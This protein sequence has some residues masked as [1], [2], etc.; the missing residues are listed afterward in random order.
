M[1][2]REFVEHG[3][4]D[5]G[6]QDDAQPPVHHPA[7]DLQQQP[8]D[9][10][11]DEPEP[12]VIHGEVE[13]G[14]DFLQG[15]FV[16][17]A[18][19]EAQRVVG[20]AAGGGAEGGGGEL[21]Q[22]LPAAVAADGVAVGVGGGGHQGG[23]K[24]LLV[25][26]HPAAFHAVVAE[27]AVVYVAEIP[28]YVR[29]IR[30]GG[31]EAEK[32]A[33][34]A[35]GLGG[36]VEAVSAQLAEGVGLPGFG[37]GV[38]HDEADIH[39]ITALMEGVALGD[40]HAGGGGMNQINIQ[41]S[42]TGGESVAVI[43]GLVDGPP[44]GVNAVGANQAALGDETAAR[45]AGIEQDEGVGSP[46]SRLV[47]RQGQIDDIAAAE[48]DLQGQGVGG[49]LHQV[50]EVL[51]RL[52]GDRGGGGLRNRRQVIPSPAWCRLGRGNVRQ[53]VLLRLR[54]HAVHIA[55][56]TINTLAVGGGRAT[57]IPRRIILP[58]CQQQ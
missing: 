48:A 56:A 10:G 3:L 18:G 23:Q 29:V 46:Q 58:P 45:K 20:P 52:A 2:L 28:L 39:Q 41:G 40:P 42:L 55:G 44:V 27:T 47:L 5:E 16:L 9:G 49:H 33:Q 32:G 19:V 1:G 54:A 17:G 26:A 34:K 36:V 13:V 6:E 14:G 15:V 11:G 43:G 8:V 25:E 21:P 53:P 51:D 24:I 7:V 30:G 31:D 12:T 57:V 22:I 35:A 4:D 38:L 50:A 37:G